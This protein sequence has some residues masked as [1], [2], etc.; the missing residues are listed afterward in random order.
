[1]NYLDILYILTPGLILLAGITLAAAM[2]VFRDKW[3]MAIQQAMKKPHKKDPRWKNRKAI[4]SFIV[5]SFIALSTLG[6]TLVPAVKA[7]GD[8]MTPGYC[9]E[10]NV[11]AVVGI[12]AA[13]TV[14][15]C[16]EPYPSVVKIDQMS[17]TS[18]TASQ[19]QLM[20]SVAGPGV[21]G[22][23]V[24]TATWTN[25]VA[26]CGGTSPSPAQVDNFNAASVKSVIGYTLNTFT[27]DFCRG[28]ITVTLVYN[29]MTVGFSRLGWNVK[30]VDNT[31]YAYQCGAPEA[32]PL[33][34]TT[35]N[36]YPNH[37]CDTQ[38]IN[39]LNALCA[40]TGTTYESFAESATCSTPSVN[41]ATSGTLTLNGEIIIC[42]EDAPCFLD[43]VD[44]STDDNMLTIPTSMLET[45][46]V[47]I[48]VEGMNTT[49]SGTFRIDFFPSLYLLTIVFSLALI[50]LGEATQ[51]QGYR[52]FAGV[53]MMV[54]G[55]ISIW[56]QN[57]L[58][59]SEVPG[60][61]I[62]LLGF[63]LVLG[64]YFI[65]PVQVIADT[66]ETINKRRNN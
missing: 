23:A 60:L 36:A 31:V 37:V 11:S 55:F 63:T 32:A 38:Q 58:G 54:A 50:R 7:Q 15:A 48:T 2:W 12:I 51:R 56:E 18:G 34:F 14:S 53:L 10:T 43:I 30:T 35:I 61:V 16:I 27:T 33:S 49:L 20:A 6:I 46:D 44:D 45:G 29:G 28:Y 3:T 22:G 57:R 62:P 25:T 4:T 9:D 13:G 1:M 24:V 52:V 64:A 26:G 5:Y 17:P 59:F 40:A 42:T 41:V 65:V 66:K 39:S 19:I 47:N 21:G 8:V